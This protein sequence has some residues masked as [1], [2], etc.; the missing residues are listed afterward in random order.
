[1][2]GL[3]G[4]ARKLLRGFAQEVAPRAQH[5]SLRCPDGHRLSGTRTDGYQALRCPT[6]GEGI[7]VLPRSPLPEPPAP[8]SPKPSPESAA[9]RAVEDD[10][11]VALS[12]A[13]PSKPGRAAAE[14]EDDEADGEIEWFDEPEAEPAAGAAPEPPRRKGPT[15]DPA[16]LA[17]EEI[18]KAGAAGRAKPRRG[19]SNR[20][21]PDPRKP[22]VEDDPGEA[23]ADEPKVVL[24]T[25]VRPKRNLL[26]FAGVILV[27]VSTVAYRSWRTARQD[28][29][30]VAALGK[31]DGLAALDAGNF[32]AARQILL[33]ARSAVDSLGDQSPE[34][35]AVRQGAQEVEIFT[36]LCP[37]TLEEILEEATRA[38]PDEWPDRFK[39]LYK[40]RTVLIDTQVVAV[41]DTQGRGSHEL[42]YRIFA[43]GEGEKP[44]GSAKIE[45]RGFRLFDQ[46]KPR[47]RDRVTFGAKLTSFSYDTESQTWRVGLEPES[48]VVIVHRQAIESLHPAGFAD[49]AEGE[50]R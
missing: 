22:A 41:P 9:A 14:T 50:A 13:W 42:A 26:I 45:T 40:G 15:A 33:P 8:A 48:G 23:D 36:Q 43:A 25:R 4:Q 24:R 11:P 35:D 10:S 7:F 18:R 37:S 49:A 46:T 27:V 28:L 29:P 44:R 3:L 2:G 12:D 5:F 16:D 39:K 6:C 1:M 32:D 30:R 21:R 17:D 31:S 47:V 19:A 34:A 20:P 38:E